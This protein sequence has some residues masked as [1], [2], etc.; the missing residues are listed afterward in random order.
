M[1]PLIARRTWRTLEPLHGMIYFAAEGA[2]EYENVGLR[3]SRMGYFASRS[4]AMGPVSAGTVVA[5][6]F[7]FY[8]P[9]VGRAIPAAWQHASPAVVLEAR[10]RAADRALRRAFDR[11]PVWDNVPEAAELA[12]VAALAAC[13][14]APGHP[15][16]AAHSELPWPAEPH[17]VLWHAQTLLREFRGDGHVALL[18]AAGLSGAEALVVHAATGEVP[19]DVLRMSRAWPDDEWGGA[20]EAVAGRGWLETVDPLAL[21]A[22]GRAERDEVEAATDR[23]ALAA[24]LTLGEERCA[25]LRELARPLS[26]AVIDAGMLI[27][28]PGQWTADEGG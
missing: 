9:L 19:A 16:L 26:R 23:L 11:A 25:R 14:H 21:S 12:R 27:P 5:T 28:V 1:E 24:Y 10:L 17:L 6:F 20:V 7:N 3:G 22:T 8:P 4:A 2:E 15:L 13:E 18:T